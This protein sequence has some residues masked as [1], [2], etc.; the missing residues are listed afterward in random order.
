L[1][2][3]DKANKV[4]EGYVLTVANQTESAFQL[5]DKIDVGGKMTNIIYQFQK[6]N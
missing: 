2:A 1:N 3:G 4:R 6:V 5:L